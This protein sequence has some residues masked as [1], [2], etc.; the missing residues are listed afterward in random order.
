MASRKKLASENNRLATLVQACGVSLA[1]LLRDGDET[2]RYTPEEYAKATKKV[3]FAKRPTVVDFDADSTLTQMQKL[4]AKDERFDA[5]HFKSI[6]RKWVNSPGALS[7]EAA[8]FFYLAATSS[9]RFTNDNSGKAVVDEIK[10]A[11]SA[12]LTEPVAR[13]RWEKL[14]EISAPTDSGMRSIGWVSQCLRQ[15]FG[16]SVAL[17][18]V[19]STKSTEHQQIELVN[20]LGPA[21]DDE[22]GAKEEE[23]LRKWFAQWLGQTINNEAMMPAI[24][25]AQRRI[26]DPGCSTLILDRF[27]DV[28]KGKTKFH[29]S[30][31]D[32]IQSLPDAEF[33]Q[34]FTKPQ[35]LPSESDLLHLYLRNGAQSVAQVFE[36]FYRLYSPAKTLD[37]L[38]SLGK[39]R[40][41]RLVP[42]LLQIC[43]DGADSPVNDLIQHAE[44][45]LIINSHESILAVCSVVLGTSELRNL[46]IRYLR[47]IVDRERSLGRQQYLNE[48]LERFSLEHQNVLKQWIH[49]P[50]D[51]DVNQLPDWLRST[52]PIFAPA[53]FAPSELPPVF[54][55]EGTALPS[56]IVANL[57]AFALSS[58]VSSLGD[59]PTL[60]QR[61]RAF[62]STLRPEDL[63][64][65]G[66]TVL[67]CDL[68]QLYKNLHTA[69]M[70]MYSHG[71]QTLFA[72]SKMTQPT[73]DISII[74]QESSIAGLF[75]THADELSY[76]FVAHLLD[77]HLGNHKDLVA[78]VPSL[79]E[80]R[81]A[82]ITKLEQHIPNLGFDSQGRLAFNL[83]K[84]KTGFLHCASLDEPSLCDE[85]GHV[86]PVPKRSKNDWQANKTQSIYSSLMWVIK[87]IRDE[88][89]R[90]LID[91]M[92]SKRRWSVTL[93]RKLFCE[94][95]LFAPMAQSLIWG[96]YQDGAIRGTFRPLSVGEMVNTRDE[97]VVIPDD[98]EIVLVHPAD[99]TK[100]EMKD[101][102]QHLI[103][104]KVIQ[105]IQQ[106]G[107]FLFDDRD[108]WAKKVY[109]AKLDLSFGNVWLRDHS[110]VENVGK[111]YSTR[112]IERAF[113]SDNFVVLLHFDFYSAPSKNSVW[114]LTMVEF[115][116]G[117]RP[118]MRGEPETI[119]NVPNRILCEIYD[120]VE[121]HLLKSSQ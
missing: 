61:I 59:D 21:F 118:G 109:K 32:L 44:H 87:L 88:M 43:F 9:A 98:C 37:V 79:S 49:S 69:M 67:S 120:L 25:M 81:E 15:L 121:Q 28:C 105:A 7:D 11:L 93:W 1:E 29:E 76:W 18:I 58:T 17:D 50:D 5:F 91:A 108:I 19:L 30:L 51:S 6:I 54:T 68:G 106:T 99:V 41:P 111:S 46:A 115:F 38:R 12:P 72:L 35:W 53:A 74:P 52:K 26:W 85:R 63:D 8:K 3:T 75:Q 119:A 31:M 20:G 114:T 4:P 70:L 82:R 95:V 112:E 42:C 33:A 94:N 27:L 65:L 102:S 40:S 55:K 92:G 22:A 83:V 62:T 36:R 78:M 34:Y 90:G 89:L 14:C 56:G 86:L 23:Q 48:C 13:A 113:S 2:W 107:K 45:L 24:I 96:I 60:I 77:R 97:S 100:A 116:V 84:N 104:Y 110:W 10:A 66:F 80:G 117:H 71:P 57:V 73:G 39:F 64:F 103:D 47:I 16:A 101:W